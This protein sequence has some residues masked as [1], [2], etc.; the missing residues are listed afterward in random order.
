MN[1]KQKKILNKVISGERLE[2][3]DALELLQAQGTDIY[4]ILETAE[5]LKQQQSKD[6]ITYVINY[7][8]NLSNICIN[9][10]QFCGFSQKPNSSAGYTLTLEQ[11]NEHLERVKNHEI[12]EICLVSGLHPDFTIDFYVEIIKHIK[13]EVPEIHIHGI[14]PAELEHALRSQDLSFLEGYRILKKAGLDSVPG[15][16]AEI[17]VPE[18]RNKICPNKI[19]SQNWIAAIKAA[20]QGGLKSTATILYGHLESLEQRVKH[21]KIIRDI[22][23]QTRG[24]TEFIPLSFIPYKTPLGE[25]K[26]VTRETCGQEDLLMIAVARMFLDNISN[27]QASWVKYGA[28]L[29]QVML[30]AGANDLGGTLFNENISRSAGRETLEY[31]PPETLKGLITDIGYK[32]QLRTTLYNLI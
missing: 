31:L 10:C 20:H 3:K 17:L 9:N 27:I 8:L 21:L 4:P 11:I 25:K 30:T 23:D 28:K 32:P 15:T 16:A 2:P 6:Q 12:T 13:A 26:K 7:N 14:T 24:F 1:S 19:S 29:A 22:Q 18:V 5:K